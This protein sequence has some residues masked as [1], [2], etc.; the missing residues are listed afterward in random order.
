MKKILVIAATMLASLS[1]SLVQAANPVADVNGLKEKMQ[2]N[3][4][5]ISSIQSDFTLVKYIS[6]GSQ[7]SACAASSTVALDTSNSFTRS[8]I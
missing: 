7:P 3:A 1:L 6:D 8:A 4:A 2:A 5:K